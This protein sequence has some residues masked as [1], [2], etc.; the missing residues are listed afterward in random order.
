MPVDASKAR[1]TSVT[2]PTPAGSGVAETT[3]NV[4]GVASTNQ[5]YMAGVGSQALPGTRL[6]TANVCAPSLSPLKDS[7]DQHGAKDAPSNW[8]SKVAEAPPVEM[9]ANATL[10]LLG[11]AGADVMVVSGGVG[12]AVGVAVVVAVAGGVGVAVGAGV[13]V[14][15]AVGVGVSVGAAVLVLVAVGVGVSVGTA[16]L[17]LVAVGVGVS[18][19]TA[20]LVLV[21]VGVGVSVGT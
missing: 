4:G 15:V 18:V 14:L 11:L 7:G 8:H 20:V 5:P 1:T 6:R 19:G 17:V 16:V 2:L 9:K 21:A 10:G 3:V 13:L 12:V